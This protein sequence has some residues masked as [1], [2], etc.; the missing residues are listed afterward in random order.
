[1]Y[2]YIFVYAVAVLFQHVA[3]NSEQ[4]TF[5]LYFLPKSFL[6][7]SVTGFENLSALRCKETR[8]F[9]CTKGSDN[10]ITS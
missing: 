10:G 4:V 7:T 2:A 3:T 1:M 8:L 9:L 6:Q 5:V